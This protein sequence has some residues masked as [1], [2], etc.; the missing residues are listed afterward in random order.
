[1]N[2]HPIRALQPVLHQSADGILHPHLQS[3]PPFP[4]SIDSPDPNDALFQQRYLSDP[5]VSAQA[6]HSLHAP[7]PFEHNAGLSHSQSH[8]QPGYQHANRFNLIQ[9]PSPHI[10][11]R[12][13]ELELQAQFGQQTE[14]ADDTPVTNHG[15]FEGLKLI[16]NPPH[17]DEWR[18]KLFHVDETI[19]LTEDQYVGK[20]TLL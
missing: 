15:Q 4:Q 13:P 17:L 20:M 12:L 7:N 5:N 3:L 19:T 11:Q 14:E 10:P 16:P 9:A 18:E 6:P 2:V 8:Y 1:M